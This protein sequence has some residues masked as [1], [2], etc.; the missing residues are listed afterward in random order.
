MSDITWESIKTKKLILLEKEYLFFLEKLEKVRSNRISLDVIGGL[1]VIYQQK[2]YLL[3]SICN[4]NINNL[5]Q[6]II[7]V[8]QSVFLPL[9]LQ[10]IINNNLGLRLIKNDKKEAVFSLDI[11]T[12]EIKDNLVKIIKT[13]T[14]NCKIN[15]RK[16]RDEIRSSIKKEKSFSQNQKDIYEKQINQLFSE[17]QEKI[18]LAEKNKIQGLKKN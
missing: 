16:I 14:D 5:H 3:K 6:L 11:I 9:I 17:Y 18:V 12:E 8:D 4:L 2:K 13:N 10:T 7:K 1:S 15:F